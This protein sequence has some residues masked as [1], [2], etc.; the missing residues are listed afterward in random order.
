[1]HNKHYITFYSKYSF[2]T[3]RVTA[4]FYVVLR[5]PEMRQDRDSQDYVPNVR[6]KT[7]YAQRL[8][9]VLDS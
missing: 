5:T 4:F 8:H 2:I 1:M 9:F 7:I 6:V 3:F